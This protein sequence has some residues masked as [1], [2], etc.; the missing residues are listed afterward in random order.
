MFSASCNNTHDDIT[1]VKVVGM[2]WINKKLNMSRMDDG[3][4]LRKFL[5]FNLKNVFQKLL[6]FRGG[7]NQGFITTKSIKVTCQSRIF[8]WYQLN[9][10]LQYSYFELIIWDALCDLWP[11]IQFIKSAKHSFVGVFM[12]LKFHKCLS[13][14][15]YFKLFKGCLLQILLGPVLSTLPHLCYLVIHDPITEDK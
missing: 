15:Y 13:R 1:T 5:K 8:L 14:P 3:I 9:F 10:T 4:S 11:F 12:F 6:F 2:V 7:Y